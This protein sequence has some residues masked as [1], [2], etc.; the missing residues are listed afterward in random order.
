[1]TRNNKLLIATLGVLAAIL[2]CIKVYQSRRAG[3]SLEP[4]V[5]Y[6]VLPHPYFSG[7]MQGAEAYEREHGVRVR[8]V[9]GQ[10]SSQANVNQN[11][12]SLFTL[13][14]RAFAIYPVDPA[15]SRGLFDRLKRAGCHVVAYGAQPEPGSAAAFAIATDTRAAATLA[16]ES[17]V[18]LIG[19]RG[20]ILNVLESLTDANTPIRDAAVRE[21]V[22]KYPD[23]EI[24]QTIG[25]VTTEQKA[26]EKIE[27]ALVARGDEVDGIVCTGYT[28]TVAA[29][30]LLSE[31][32]ARPGAKRIRFVGLDTDERVL[33]AIRD[34]SIDMTL[35]QNPFGHGYI[36]CTLLGLLLE[37]WEPKAP[38][39]F[40][41]SGSVPV[42]KENLDTFEAGIREMTR[43]IV[44]ELKMKYLNPPNALESE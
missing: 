29:A 15:G 31:R 3:A 20:R 16:A 9:T 28:T 5:L 18:K 35:A 22:A 19:G 8:L 2:A 12:E 33:A 38:Y 14:H 11:V 39:Q 1:M 27:S 23:V 30:M 34:G 25:D 42:T 6:C 7:V 40:I 4:I 36:S 24:I 21:V 13:G 44:A 32:H 41:D 43:T 26:R 10:E 37:G 17:L